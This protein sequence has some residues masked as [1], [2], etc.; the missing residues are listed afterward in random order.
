MARLRAACEIAS[1]VVEPERAR[2]LWVGIPPLCDF[3]LLNYPERHGA[4]VTK[5]ML[6]FLTGFTV[7]PE[8]I[9][10]KKPL[11]SIARA[12]LSS[13]AN[14]LYRGVIDYLVKA[15]KDYKVDGVVSVV[16]RTCGLIPGMQRLTKEAIFEAT[17][18]PAVVFDLDGIDEREY[19]AAASR[20][21]LD[22]FVETLLARKGG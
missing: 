17:G 19:D 1:G 4:V 9:D 11:E 18:A 3:T 21:N 8:E 22:S 14:P 5:S 13:P 12:L 10:P 20:A 16:K 15:A 6:E 7:P 2:L